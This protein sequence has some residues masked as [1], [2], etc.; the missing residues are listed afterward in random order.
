MNIRIWSAPYA[1]PLY[2]FAFFASETAFID[3]S[4]LYFDA[5]MKYSIL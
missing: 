2:V 4:E 5:Y 3:Y 1:I